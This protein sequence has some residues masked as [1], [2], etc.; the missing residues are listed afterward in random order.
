[1]LHM[2]RKVHDLRLDFAFFRFGLCHR[3]TRRGEWT[4]RAHEKSRRSGRGAYVTCMSSQME[5][6]VLSPVSPDC[7]FVLTASSGC[8]AM[9]ENAPPAPAD[10]A[11][12]IDSDAMAPS[13]PSVTTCQGE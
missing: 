1:M 13:L 5:G 7:I 3:Q 12:T 6:M 11:A 4:K 2:G 9:D 8:R 10:N